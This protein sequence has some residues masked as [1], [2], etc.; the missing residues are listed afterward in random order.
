MYY[1][2]SRAHGLEQT[3]LTR[4]LLFGTIKYSVKS[5]Q[6]LLDIANDSVFCQLERTPIKGD[7][8]FDLVLSTITTQI[9][10]SNTVHVISDHDAV[11]VH[12]DTKVKHASKKPRTVS[13]QE[14]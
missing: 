10:N 11:M 12:I 8:V 9:N 4:V 7:N 2:L 1:F 6:T 3:P 13:A 14:R 5:N